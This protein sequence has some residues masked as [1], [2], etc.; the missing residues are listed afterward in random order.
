MSVDNLYGLVSKSISAVP[1]LK[2][3]GN[4]TLIRASNKPKANMVL[5]INCLS[6]LG[7]LVLI[8]L[9]CS[10]VKLCLEIISFPHTLNIVYCLFDFF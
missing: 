9:I 1:P 3:K 7:Y 8:E 2:I 5:S 10:S 4:L 6:S